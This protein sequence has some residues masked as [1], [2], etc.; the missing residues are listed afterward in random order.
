MKIRVICGDDEF[1]N[2]FT[3]DTED[4][5]WTCPKCD[6]IITNPHF[7]FLTARV[8]HSRARPDQVNW[9]ELL[10]NLYEDV[11]KYFDGQMSVLNDAEGGAKARDHLGKDAV[12]FILMSVEDEDAFMDGFRERF[13]GDAQKMHEALLEEAREIAVKLWEIQHIDEK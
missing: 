2:E 9:E 8:M 7:P 12:E 3:A 1:R 5:R 13:D 10:D 4:P 11:R 6:R